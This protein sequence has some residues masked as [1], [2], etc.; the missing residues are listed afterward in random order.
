MKDNLIT[1]LLSI[2]ILTLIGC[3]AV[4]GFNIL[5]I[6]GGTSSQN[7]SNTNETIYATIETKEDVEAPVVANETIQLNTAEN[8][9]YNNSN[10]VS[11]FMYDQLDNYSKII[12]DG[13]QNS[14]EQMKSGTYKVE[15]GNNFDDVLANDDGQTVLGEYYQS[16]VEAFIYDN[17]D[18]FYLEPTKMYL[19]IE[20]STSITKKTSN[21]YISNSGQVYLAEG[22]ISESQVTQAQEQIEQVKNNIINSLSGSDYDKIKQIHD[23]LVENIEYDTTIS[24]SNIYNLYG[25][26]VNNECVC[27][28]YAK[29]FKYLVNQAGID[30]VIVVGTGVNSAGETESHAWNYVQLNNTWYA[31][32]ATW[33]DPIIQ[34]RAL[35]TNSYKYKYFL[36]GLNTMNE[37]H[38][39]SGQF[40]NDGKVFTYPQVS[41]EDY[42]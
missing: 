13:L 9:T 14:K 16:A 2:I 11:N 17:P 25:A 3:V 27:E 41:Y 26:L 39:P 33:D 1:G 36:K 20:T 4:T 32:D 29:A 23:Y 18:V 7:T 34:G 8:I 40:T 24:K 30:C 19:N 5:G 38:E 10:S 6:L 37:D 42:K 22:F 12:Y 15:Y 31:V 28:G 35:F 21:V